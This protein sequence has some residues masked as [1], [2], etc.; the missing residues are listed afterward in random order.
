MDNKRKEL[1]DLK[2]NRLYLSIAT[3]LISGSTIAKYLDIFSVGAIPPWTSVIG[4]IFLLGY[5]I[6]ISVKI[7]NL[8][9]DL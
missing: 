5:V 6:Y 9:K 7:N 2:R 3:L 8:E 4:I 1:R